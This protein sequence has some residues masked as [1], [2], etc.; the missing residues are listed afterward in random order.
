M[1]RSPRECQATAE[2]LAAVTV[3]GVPRRRVRPVGGRPGIG[4][5]VRRV[6]FVVRVVPELLAVIVDHDACEEDLLEYAFRAFIAALGRRNGAVTSGAERL[7]G[8]DASRRVLTQRR[9]L[10]GTPFDR[11]ATAGQQRE[12]CEREREPVVHSDQEMAGPVTRRP[13]SSA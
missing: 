13:R 5:R 1:R 12:N 10:R 8:V 4:R 7:D 6:V 11:V 9:D 3:N 2:L